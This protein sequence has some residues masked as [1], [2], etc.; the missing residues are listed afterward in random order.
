MYNAEVIE[1][2]VDYAEAL[3]VEFEQLSDEDFALADTFL[4]ALA[5]DHT[6]REGLA[7]NKFRQLEDPKFDTEVVGSFIKEGYNISRVKLW[8]PDGTVL[9]FR[10]IYALQHHGRQCKIVFLGLMPRG[11]NYEF[12]SQFGRSVC[13][14]YDD[15][16]VPKVPRG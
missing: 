3:D 9:P 1:Y 6:V 14:R 10:L 2:L 13:E 15:L 5:H 16:G 12:S 8:R 4:G 11:N 7:L